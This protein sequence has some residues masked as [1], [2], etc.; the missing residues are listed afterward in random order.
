MFKNRAVGTF[1]L[2]VSFVYLGVIFLIN[3]MSHLIAYDFILYVWPAILILLGIEVLVNYALGKEQ[4][5]RYDGVSIFLLI[6]LTLFSL[7]MG[8][9]GFAVEHNAELH[10]LIRG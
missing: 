6:I 4:K 8:A 2:G 1:T 5:T 3:A 9:V 10:Q 7:C